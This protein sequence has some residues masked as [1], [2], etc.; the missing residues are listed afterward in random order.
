MGNIIDCMNLP[1]SEE[2]RQHFPKNEGIGMGLHTCKSILAKLGG[3]MI[4][5]SG[6][7]T[8]TSFKIQIPC[9]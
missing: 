4:I 1:V 3:K 8:L 7:N 9:E 5:N 2:I 6:N